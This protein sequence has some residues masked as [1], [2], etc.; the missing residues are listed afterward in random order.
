MTDILLDTNIFVGALQRNDGVNRRILEL[1]F[2]DAYQPVM[3]EALYFEYQDLIARDSVFDDSSFSRVERENFIDDYCSI[4]R[5]VD[6][7]YRW[8]PNLKDE[9][10]NHIIELAM[11]SGVKEIISWNKKDFRNSDLLMPDLKIL[12]PVELIR[13]KHLNE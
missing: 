8:R 4:C 9:A 2:L 13:K 3:G 7:H 11:A 1:C 5:W 10:D 6:I 12:T